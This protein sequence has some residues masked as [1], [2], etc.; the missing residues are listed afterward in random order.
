MN[1]IKEKWQRGECSIGAWLAIPSALT[2]EI[3]GRAGYDHV[4]VDLQHGM[5]D[6]RDALGMFAAIELGG[7]VPFARPT[8]NEPGIIGRLLDGGALG[9][10]IPMVNSRDDALA[11]A[12]ACRYA[13]RGAR[14]F[15]P[16]RASLSRPSSPQEADESV[17]C[18]TM[19]ETAEAV[20]NIDEILSV[21]GV[22]A[23]Y[24]GPSDLSV[25]LGL[26]PGP[27]NE[28]RSFLDA[29]EKVLEACR[30]RG[31]TAGIHTNSKLAQRRREE[32]FQLMTVS[33]D[34]PLFR[35]AIENDLAAARQ[36][37]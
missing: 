35:A 25:S 37:D 26:P 3:V 21:P 34:L 13:P 4:C 8:W 36:Q 5:S 11:A 19:I 33:A 23:A 31:V 30:R 6:Y 1:P 24:I 9:L 20:A 2:A 16:T 32:G 22:D 18:I 14:S 29:L 7:S 28:D 10:I 12:A 27:H 17:L 15:G